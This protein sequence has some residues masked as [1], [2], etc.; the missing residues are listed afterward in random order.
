MR[1]ET[2]ARGRKDMF[3]ERLL[4][5]LKSSSAEENKKTTRA[6]EKI[7]NQKRLSSE[8]FLKIYDTLWK[9]GPELKYQSPDA[10]RHFE[11]Q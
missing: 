7:K 11:P 5:A 6:I 2:I 10:W 1:K 3:K 8:E 4:E 9:Q